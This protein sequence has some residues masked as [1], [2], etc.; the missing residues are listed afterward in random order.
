MKGES[1]FSQ[2]LALLPTIMATAL[3]FG[4]VAELTEED[5]V[6]IA[7]G[8][9]G[10]RRGIIGLASIM[11]LLVVALPLA[12]LGGLAGDVIAFVA[13]VSWGIWIFWQQRRWDR[14]DEE[15]GAALYR[16]YHG[17]LRTTMRHMD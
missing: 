8:R 2:M 9:A 14:Q 3:I 12:K 10:R 16:Q 5:M 17:C 15:D 6:S 7:R 11:V 13:I 1:W 4:S